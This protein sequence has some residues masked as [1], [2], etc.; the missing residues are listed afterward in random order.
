MRRSFLNRSGSLRCT[1][2]V[3]AEVAEEEKARAAVLRARE[4]GTNL[5]S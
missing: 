4:S 3:F 1:P 5:S 2:P